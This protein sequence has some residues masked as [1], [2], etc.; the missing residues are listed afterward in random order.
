MSATYTL[1]AAMI[2]RMTSSRSPL[3]IGVSFSLMSV[4]N[5]ATFME[6]G[7]SPDQASQGGRCPP[8]L[9]SALPLAPGRGAR[10]A[11][12]DE[13][14]RFHVI[15]SAPV[16]EVRFQEGQRACAHVRRV[17]WTEVCAVFRIIEPHRCLR[18]GFQIRD[19]SEGRETF[20]ERGDASRRNGWISA[21]EASHH[22]RVHLGEVQ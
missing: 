1:S 14:L 6:Q 5:K 7:T 17:Y 15:A 22:L 9:P 13:Y 2:F 19:A 3:R 10:S 12:L 11:R 18:V 21:S 8:S 16:G 20:A 4:G